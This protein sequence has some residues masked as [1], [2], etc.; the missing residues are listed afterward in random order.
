MGVRFRERRVREQVL[1][2]GVGVGV[3]VGVSTEVLDVDVLDVLMTVDFSEFWTEAV[4]SVGDV[5]QFESSKGVFSGFEPTT[6]LSG[7]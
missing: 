3:G 6:S 1:G 4:F 5:S 2:T 7:V